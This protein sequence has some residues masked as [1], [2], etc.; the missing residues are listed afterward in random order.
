[1]N[2]AGTLQ[3]G[4]A[5]RS[6]RAL[7]WT[8]GIAF[9]LLG[10]T[11][12]AMAASSLGLASAAAVPGGTAVVPVQLQLDG[13]AVAVQFDVRFDPARLR[14]GFAAAGPA[15]A[16]HTTGSSVPAT[17]VARFIVYSLSN[18]PLGNGTIVNVP[19]VVATNA[20]AGSVPLTVTN[21][22]VADVLGRS[23][24]PVGLNNGAVEVRSGT[25]PI[26]EGPSIGADGQ[27][28]LRLNGQAGQTYTLQVSGD[29]V[30]WQT[31][32]SGVA[33]GGTAIFTD[34]V[35]AGP[36]ARFYRAVEEP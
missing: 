24:G 12:S 26:F 35:I 27:I 36:A 18:E 5:S 2:D 11:E 20:P 7:A 30:S 10:G 6:M 9:G 22:I 17:G 19:F 33:T 25:A 4:S 34:A 31:L 13:S 16:A 23:V 3:R 28:T 15:A 21:V 32:K 29:L 14:T 8:A 1:M